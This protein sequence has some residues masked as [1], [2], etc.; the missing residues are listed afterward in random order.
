MMSFFKLKRANIFNLR[1]SLSKDIIV[2][3]NLN[4]NTTTADDSINDIIINNNLILGPIGKNNS[5]SQF[6]ILAFQVV[7]LIG[8]INFSKIRDML[9][10]HN[11]TLFITNNKLLYNEN[12]KIVS[13]NQK[14]YLQILKDM[15]SVLK[16]NLISGSVHFKKEFAKLYSSLK[17][18]IEES[19]IDIT[20]ITLSFDD[21]YSLPKRVI[22]DMVPFQSEIISKSNSSVE[23]LNLS[24]M[25][26]SNILGSFLL[27][28][29]GSSNENKNFNNMKNINELEE[30]NKNLVVPPLDKK[31]LEE[32]KSSGFSRKAKFMEFVKKK[33]DQ[34]SKKNKFK[35]FL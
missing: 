27:G 28:S 9:S 18:L 6:Y 15:V 13:K 17:M 26:L 2:E 30:L 21:I 20:R 3:N 5:L 1:S 33:L 22:T 19:E 11:L 14:I 24:S 31:A 25:S 8:L 10:P 23:P 7:T 12:L 4:S 35:I 29:F 34:H 32:I 16:K